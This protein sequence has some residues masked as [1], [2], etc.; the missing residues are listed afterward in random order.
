MVNNS[1][2]TW[3]TLQEKSYYARSARVCFTVASYWLIDNFTSMRRAAGTAPKQHHTGEL[4][5]S[6]AGHKG[7]TIN[8]PTHRDGYDRSETT[9]GKVLARRIQLTCVFFC[10]PTFKT[11]QT[12]PPELFDHKKNTQANCMGLFDAI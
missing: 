11:L 12:T 5:L 9:V 10:V 4:V 2:T 6:C 7:K 1:S 8:L 3:L